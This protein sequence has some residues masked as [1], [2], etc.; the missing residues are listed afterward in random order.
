M[1]NHPF[2]A[3]FNPSGEG[4]TTLQL[5]VYRDLPRMSNHTFSAGFNSSGEGGTTLQL[6]VY[7]DP[8]GGCDPFDTPDLDKHSTSYP[9]THLIVKWFHFLSRD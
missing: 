3:V 5:G 8:S 2:S 1:S 6:G 7:K 4:G 9:Y